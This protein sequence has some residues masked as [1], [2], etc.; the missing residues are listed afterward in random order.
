MCDYLHDFLFLVYFQVIFTTDFVLTACSRGRS[1]RKR[2]LVYTA[3]IVL[4]LSFPL[5]ADI[6]VECN[7][8]EQCLS[9]PNLDGTCNQNESD[10]TLCLFNTPGPHSRGNGGDGR[11]VNS[12]GEREHSVCGRRG[13]KISVK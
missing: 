5:V 7:S 8:N 11:Q 10:L 9:D 13:R 6:A 3:T 1:F 2:D 12:P 4:S